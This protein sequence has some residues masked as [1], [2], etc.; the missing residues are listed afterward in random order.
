MSFS[1]FKLI[2]QSEIGSAH[3]TETLLETAASNAQNSTSHAKSDDIM[4]VLLAH[5]K[6]NNNT[7]NAVKTLPGDESDS[8]S[9]EMMN[10]VKN[11]NDMGNLIFQFFFYHN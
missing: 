5:E 4:S 6:K 11:D 9:D 7:A 8:S 3:S 10:D 1:I 2:L